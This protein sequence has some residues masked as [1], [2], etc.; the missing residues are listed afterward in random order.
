MG[1][2]SLP[3][4]LE[5]ETTGARTNSRRRT[6]VISTALVLAVAAGSV[7][8]L[9]SGLLPI[10]GPCGGDS[11]P[12]NVVASPDIAPAV[13]AMAGKARKDAI[14]T[15]GQCLDVKVTAR[16]AHE[17]AD[18][19]GQRPARS[20]FQVWIPDSSLW[21]DQVGAERGTP[22][23]AAGTI[24]SSPIGL[25]AVPE[26]AKELG[27][28]ERDFSWS[29]LSRAATSGDELR[30][31]MADPAHSATGLLALARINASNAKKAKDDDEAD[32]RTASAA[33]LLYQR[34]ADSDRQA[35][36][37]LPHDSSGATGNS[38]RNEALLL[39]EQAA[40]AH[41]T[42]KDNGPDLEL[43]SPR[44]GGAQLDY[45]YTL[46][47][48]DQLTA[49]QTRA[50]N[51]FMTLLGGVDGQRALR[52]RGFR[53]GNG[54]P[55][56][57]ITRAAGGRVPQPYAAGL[58]APP[59]PKELQAL[60]GKWTST[61]QS[62]RIATVVDASP[63]MA[64]QVPGLGRSR[65]ELAKGSLL[66]AVE[67][68]TPDDEVGLWKFSTLL[69]GTKDYVELS[70]TTRLGERGEGGETHRD[71]LT[72]ALNSLAPV[73]AGANGLYD[74]TLAAYE[75]ATKRYVN[76]KLNTVV[77][78]T[79][80]TDDDLG[81][82]GL[83]QLVD[84]LKKAADP[85]RPVPLIALAIGPETDQAALDRMVAPTG[86]SAHRV[87]DPSQIH[88]VMLKAIT[89]AGSAGLR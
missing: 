86:G 67:S 15:D 18:S 29:E 85:A 82:I 89:K 51:R 16:V 61:V 75:Q 33:K 47:D 49:A 62:A 6:V 56:D 78:I 17:V 12:L 81:S 48:D 66:K 54:E 64:G 26:A 57:K 53:A 1:R 27:L 55:N 28:S 45:P 2:H 5:P 69:D 88:E 38:R 24:A 19:L 60:L 44:D 41:N 23:T 52:E 36:A 10:G 30:L 46:V 4:G 73:P 13:E 65:M 63:S 80:G 20:E 71:E 72:A 76:G 59:A 8:A 25:G 9:R 21:V 34:A 11:V 43:F 74:T 39:S 83:D 22:L 31:G 68:F 84:K 50:A 14:R 79:D 7:V 87:S 70:P 35:L 42:G 58:D 32:I 37:T 40:H 3:D 77:I